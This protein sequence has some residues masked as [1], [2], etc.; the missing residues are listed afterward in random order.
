[1]ANMMDFDLYPSSVCGVQQPK[2]T[3]NLNAIRLTSNNLLGIWSITYFCWEK[4]GRMAKAT[5]VFFI[6]NDVLKMTLWDIFVNLSMFGNSTS[7]VEL[8]LR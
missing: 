7:G 2:S 6:L 4:F 8:F 1:M 3:R 5:A